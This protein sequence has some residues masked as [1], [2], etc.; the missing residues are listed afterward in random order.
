MVIFTFCLL[1]LYTRF[2][3]GLLIGC[4]FGWFRSIIIRSAFLPSARQSQSVSPIAFAP[5]VTAIFRTSSAGTADASRSWS[6][7]SPVT[8]NISRNIS[9]QLLLAGPSVPMAILT[10][11][12]KNAVVLAMPLASFVLDPGLVTAVSPFLRKSSI[13]SSVNQMQWYPP[14]PCSNKPRESR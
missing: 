7:P 6:F 5:P 3:I 1:P 8:K 11:C 9:R 4:I 12:F 2:F 13:S 14:P 10:P